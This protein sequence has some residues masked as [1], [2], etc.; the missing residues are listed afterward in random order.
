MN[1]TAIQEAID[2]YRKEVGGVTIVVIAHRLSTIQDAD[3]I[4]VIKDGVLREQGQHES[5]NAIPDGIYAGFHAKQARAEAE[6][7]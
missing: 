2:T 1:E 4:L 7:A 3:N 6:A 5:L